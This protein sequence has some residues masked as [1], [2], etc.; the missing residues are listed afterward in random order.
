[1][2]SWCARRPFDLGVGKGVI[3]TRLD[4]QKMSTH[5]ATRLISLGIFA[6]QPFPIDNLKVI[7][8]KTDDICRTVRQQNHLAHAKLV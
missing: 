1:M 7:A 8:V 6:I 2:A 4:N 5:L 3:E